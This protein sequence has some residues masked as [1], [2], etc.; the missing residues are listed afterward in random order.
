MLDLFDA[1]AFVE[2]HGDQIDDVNPLVQQLGGALPG[3]AIAAGVHAA[4]VWGSTSSGLYIKVT[5]DAIVGVSFS[6]FQFLG[7]FELQGALH[8]WIVSIE[9]S[10]KLDIGA[11]TTHGSTNFWFSGDV[12]G[13]VDFLFFERRGLRSRR[14][15]QLRTRSPMRLR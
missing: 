14:A 7:I 3:L 4:I 10:A 5:A 15:R 8:L 11:L 6:P 1:T 13:E 2:I 12:C 9:A